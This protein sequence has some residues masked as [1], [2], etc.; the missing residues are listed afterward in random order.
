MKLAEF[1]M[2]H[3]ELSAAFLTKQHIES[4]NII[5]RKTNTTIVLVV[6][7][8]ILLA[9]ALATS[10]TTNAAILVL[11]LGAIQAA[12]TYKHHVFFMRVVH[13]ELELARLRKV[14]AAVSRT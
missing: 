13:A 12:I 8:Y 7:G 3:L 1:V 9:L 5:R 2:P 6:A 10:T 14:M 4:T 11:S